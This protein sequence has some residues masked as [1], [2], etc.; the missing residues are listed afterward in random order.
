MAHERYT[1]G[2][3]V[4]NG[5]S[6]WNLEG[7]ESKNLS[8]GIQTL[9][10]RAAG[11][12]DASWIAV[13][14]VAPRLSATCSDVETFLSNVAMSGF[15]F[16]QSTTYTTVEN[17]F[18][19]LP[20]GGVR[21]ATACVKGAMNKGLIVP[22]RLTWGLEPPATIEF[23]IIATFDGTN[24]PLILSVSQTMSGTPVIG[25]MFRAGPVTI[26]GTTG[27]SFTSGSFDFGLSEEAA[28]AM[29]QIYPTRV[30]IQAREPEFRFPTSDLSILNT[31]GISGTAQ[32]ATD[33]VIA[34]RHMPNRSSVTADTEEEHIT[35]TVDDGLIFWEEGGGSNDSDAESTVV[36]KPIFDGTNEMVVFATDQ[37][38]SE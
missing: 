19:N 5:S 26:N 9:L 35:M 30:H 1:L 27:D 15:A 17:Y 7:L 4:V 10:R 6:T 31:Y 2:R 29:D 16:P 18:V 3:I 11:Q 23:D 33:S 37:A 36:L 12:P 14:E 20:D 25:E 8:S 28:R 32:S 38:L 22:R 24:A 34:L 21:D 13:T